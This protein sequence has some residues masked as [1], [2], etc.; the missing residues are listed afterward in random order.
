MR[1][2]D[3]NKIAPDQQRKNLQKIVKVNKLM[4]RKNLQIADMLYQCPDTNRYPNVLQMTF[5][6]HLVLVL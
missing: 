4:F 1:R 2:Q 5:F 3:R 6:H